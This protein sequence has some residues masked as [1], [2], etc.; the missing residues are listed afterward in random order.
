M[1][2]PFNLIAIVLLLIVGYLIYTEIYPSSSISNAVVKY[3]D[4]KSVVKMP[5]EETPKNESTVV[6]ADNT[7]NYSEYNGA[8]NVVNNVINIIPE[9]EPQV[10]NLSQNVYTYNDAKIACKAMGAELASVDQVMDAY[11]NG[12]N[13]CNYGWTQQQMALYPIQKDYWK[14]VQE[15]PEMKKNCGGEPGVNGGYFKNPELM[16]GANCYGIKPSPKEGE[17][18][19]EYEIAKEIEMNEEK[20]FQFK[21]NT[22][23]VAPFSNH[24]WSVYN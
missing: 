20:Y 16:F 13:W 21:N 7:V 23:R 15:N 17:D 6:P 9:T 1:K 8:N 4:M 22:P 19:P 18:L 12:A 24:K 3:L 10:F 5:S 14:R 11:N 2:L